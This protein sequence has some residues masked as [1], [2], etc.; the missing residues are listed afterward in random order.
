MQIVKALIIIRIKDIVFLKT[1]DSLTGEGAGFSPERPAGYSRLPSHCRHCL[2][3]GL[4]RGFDCG[5][6]GVSEGSGDVVLVPADAL[7]YDRVLEA[8]LI[9]VEASRS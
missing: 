4:E 1:E 8:V 7:I 6:G 5:V 2:S 3:R 9:V